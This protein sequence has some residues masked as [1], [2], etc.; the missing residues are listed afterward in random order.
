MA[1]QSYLHWPFFDPAHRDWAARV[2]EV[3]QSLEVDHSDTDTA[4][5]AL[6]AQMGAA[7]LLQPTSSDDGRFDLRTLCLARETLAR[8]DGLADFAFAMQGLGTGAITLFGT[9]AQ[10]A[11]WLP[12]T[13][14]GEAIAAFALTEPG[15][16]SDVANSTMTATRDGDDYILNGEKTWISNGG[17]ADVYT[18]FAR[19]GEAPGAKGLSAFIVTPDLLGFEI[20]ERLDTIAPHPLATLRFTDC[21]VPADALLGAPGQGFKVAMSVLD[22]FRATV[23]AAALGFARR[24]LDEALARVTTRQIAGSP[25]A[26]LQMV[27]GHIADM[28]VDVDASAL[29]VYRAAWT[30]DS[31]A[32]RITREAA[33]AKLFATDQAQQVIDKAVQLFG[34]DGVRSGMAVETLYREIRALRIYEGASDVQK[35]IIAR[36]TLAA[37]EGGT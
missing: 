6:V 2:E 33:M 27:Q 1:D 37:F 15:S 7:G 17:I 31:G 18:L 29:L 28:A 3:A 26:D 4:C 5:R 12:K 36:Q 35:I 11:E 24:A 13:R 22:V 25:L 30:R 32:P 19:T 14:A 9:E 20:A 16:G 23:A 21:R 8:H 34:G 10:K